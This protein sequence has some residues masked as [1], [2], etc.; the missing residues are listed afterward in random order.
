MYETARSMATSSCSSRK[1]RCATCRP[2]VISSSSCLHKPNI[3]LTARCIPKLI[4]S[5]PILLSSR[6]VQIQRIVFTLRQFPE[7]GFYPRPR[8]PSVVCIVSRHAFVCRTIPTTICPA[9]FNSS[10]ASSFTCVPSADHRN[11]YIIDLACLRCSRGFRSS[12]KS[13]MHTKQQ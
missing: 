2:V 7:D 3:M 1:L 9:V 6:S 4:Y 12:W 8:L 13:L 11:S 10:N 5:Q